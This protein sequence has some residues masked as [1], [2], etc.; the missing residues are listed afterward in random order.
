[1]WVIEKQFT[2]RY[3]Y[4]PSLLF[5]FLHCCYTRHFLP[6]LVI[7]M[8]R[9]INGKRP[10]NTLNFTQPLLETLKKITRE[11][12]RTPWNSV[13]DNVKNIHTK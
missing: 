6:N 12:L 1:M 7:V 10:Q 4:V 9:I 13:S 11:W 8:F 3:I 2:A 5:L